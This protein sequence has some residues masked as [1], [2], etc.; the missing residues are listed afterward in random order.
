M[1]RNGRMR[2]KYAIL[3]GFMQIIILFIILW[4]RTVPACIPLEDLSGSRLRLRAYEE[5]IDKH[6]SGAIPNS[7]RSN[8]GN[9]SKIW[10]E[11]FDND[12][13]HPY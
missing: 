13:S 5:S 2:Y 3:C 9:P 6:E 11:S 10:E 1:V 12:S 7:C 4:R 8:D